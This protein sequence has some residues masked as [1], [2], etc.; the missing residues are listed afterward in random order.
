M[1]TKRTYY[2]VDL[3]D[4]KMLVHNKEL[5]HMVTHLEYEIN[6]RA[7]RSATTQVKV[8]VC[9]DRFQQDA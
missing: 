1:D 7:P 9:R 6:R 3:N 4:S 8:L 2:E 5:W